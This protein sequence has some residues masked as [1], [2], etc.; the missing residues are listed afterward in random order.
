MAPEP[1]KAELVAQHDEEVKR[2][3]AEHREEVKS[4]K[5]DAESKKAPD[6]EFVAPGV[7]V[8]GHPDVET[9][10]N[11]DA[12]ENQFFP[13][14]ELPAHA[15]PLNLNPVT[16]G[17]FLDEVRAVEEVNRRDADNRKKARKAL[18]EANS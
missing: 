12:V 15:R 16:N 17:P 11:G 4:L 6:K 18:E 14:R 2:L 8:P 10:E 9:Y 7:I 1:T 3:K 5:A 13:S